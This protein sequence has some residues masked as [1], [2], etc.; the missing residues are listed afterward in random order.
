[1]IP[2]YQMNKT[3]L[4]LLLLLVIPFYSLA[5]VQ[6]SGRVINAPKK[7][8]VH[9]Y[10]YEKGLQWTKM[11]LAD[12]TLDATGS[13]S[14]HF[15]LNHSTPAKIE[16]GEQYANLYLS[17]DDRLEIETDYTDFDEKLIFQ[18]VGSPANNYLAK[19]SLIGFNEKAY[20][21]KKIKALHIF[22]TYIDS[23]ANANRLL[24]D[25]HRSEEMSKDFE[26][27]MTKVLT[28]RYIN[29]RHIFSMRRDKK[30]NAPLFK[31]VP[32]SYYDFLKNLNINDQ[33]ALDIPEYTLA[34]N[35]YCYE[36][37][38]KNIGRSKDTNVSLQEQN[39]R[40]I[41]KSYDF[42]KNQF[43]GNIR[44]FLLSD[45]LK[46][47]FSESELRNA[48]ANS[49][50]NQYKKDC[51][52][53]VYVKQIESI[54]KKSLSV[55]QGKTAPEI[56]LVDINGTPFSLSSMKGKVVYIDFW[57]TW[58]KPCIDDLEHTRKLQEKFKNNPELLI[59]KICLNDSNKENW[60]K[61]V[62]KEM[63]KGLN[64]YADE[65]NSTML[66]KAYN[67][68]SFPKYVLIDKQGKIIQAN[69]LGPLEIEGDIVRALGE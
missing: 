31:I 10:Y 17:M 43:Q 67:I 35:R 47:V 40:A 51:N 66:M 13:F 56:N 33:E 5:Q 49:L 37:N 21:F 69:A 25:Q 2:S 4:I 65:L 45:Y 61:I 54:Y 41:M 16:I 53:L 9:L 68:N 6:I 20:D 50:M 38:D 62:R 27:Y 11:V 12:T 23:I 3:R 52:N 30:T 14:V 19:E 28:Y 44:D 18:G 39:E 48:F 8:K 58:C 29:V 42:R 32:V 55:S 7:A 15:T 60:E 46:Q 36:M 1:M 26:R 63:P 24:F 59:I 64:I 22:E 34:L 57:A